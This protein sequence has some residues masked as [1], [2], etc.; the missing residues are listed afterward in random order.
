MQLHESW[1]LDE[2]PRNQS[3]PQTLVSWN[4]WCFPRNQF[5][6]QFLCFSPLLILLDRLLNICYFFVGFLGTVPGIVGCWRVADKSI[7]FS[8][9]CKFN[10]N[11]SFNYFLSCR[12]LFLGTGLLNFVIWLSKLFIQS[13]ELWISEQIGRLHNSDFVQRSREQLIDL[14]LEIKTKVFDNDNVMDPEVCSI[15]Q[16]CNAY[17]SFS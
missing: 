6:I 13:T 7:N 5:W 14:E 2:W 11:F 12:I 4:S 17:I 1:V 10:F 16:V 8:I 9:K 3:I 15:C